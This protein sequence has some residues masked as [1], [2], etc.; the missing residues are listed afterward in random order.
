MLNAVSIKV[1]NNN[2]QCFIS[3]GLK[4]VEV[5][6]YGLEMTKCLVHLNLAGCN[7]RDEGGAIVAN[8]LRSNDTIKVQRFS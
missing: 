3:I 4:G 7:I 8:A 1:K 5:L 6:K 2:R